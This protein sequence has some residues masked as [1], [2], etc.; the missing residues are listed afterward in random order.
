MSSGRKLIRS[1]FFKYYA[2]NNDIRCYS[3][4]STNFYS[5]NR[6]ESNNNGR[7]K[8]KKKKFFSII[9]K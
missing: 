9:E 2:F 7:K 6:F 4:D 8:K 5:G 1:E 3:R